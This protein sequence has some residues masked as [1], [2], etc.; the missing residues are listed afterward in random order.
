MSGSKKV[1]TMLKIHLHFLSK[2]YVNISICCYDGELNENIFD[3]IDIYF[4]Y[5]LKWILYFEMRFN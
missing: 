1:H 2:N 3:E 4:K 5:M